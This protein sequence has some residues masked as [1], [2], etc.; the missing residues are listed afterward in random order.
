MKAVTGDARNIMA[1][2]GGLS[3]GMG[4]TASSIVSVLKMTVG[5]STNKAAKMDP[6]M[7]PVAILSG[8]SVKSWAVKR[9]GQPMG[10]S[11]DLR[12]RSCTLLPC[13]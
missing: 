9:Q 1:I 12:R 6:G 7:L 3:A 11:G 5:E 2:A 4:I 10:F 13:D 8:Q